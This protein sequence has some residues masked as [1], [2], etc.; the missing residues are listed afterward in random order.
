MA[1]QKV[2]TSADG[3]SMVVLAPLPM[4]VKTS[5]YKDFKYS[6]QVVFLLLGQL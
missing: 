3:P 2:Q 6:N 4:P 5:V 1:S